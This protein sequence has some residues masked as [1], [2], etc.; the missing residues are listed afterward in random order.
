MA[1]RDCGPGSA[2]RE[3]HGRMAGAWCFLTGLN[4][5]DKGFKKLLC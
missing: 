2:Y 5:A 4:T 3:S 1:W